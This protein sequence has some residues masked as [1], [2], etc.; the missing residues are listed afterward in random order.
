MSQETKYPFRIDVRPLLTQGGF[1]YGPSTLFILLGDTLERKEAEET[2]W[3]EVVHML[4]RVKG[5]G[6]Q[7]EDEVDRIAKK[8][9]AVCP[10]IIELCGL[11]DKFKHEDAHPR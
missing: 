6:P 9:A 8:L 5:P 11:E 3:H 10:E 1:G 2:L 7:D 4:K